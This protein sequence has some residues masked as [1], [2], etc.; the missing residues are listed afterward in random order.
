MYLPRLA[1]IGASYVNPSRDLTPVLQFKES[2]FH[3]A[4]IMIQ[5]T[6][7]S[8]GMWDNRHPSTEVNSGMRAKRHAA[9]H[10]WLQRRL[11]HDSQHNAASHSTILVCQQRLLCVADLSEQDPGVLIAG[12]HLHHQDILDR[13]PSW[14]R[15]TKVH[16]I[17]IYTTAMMATM[18]SCASKLVFTLRTSC[19]GTRLPAVAV[20]KAVCLCT[21][22][23]AYK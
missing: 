4:P 2:R 23:L 19:T 21:H 22:M 3:E 15:G 20:K 10:L 8:S 1:H 16:Y 14:C 5:G 11:L 18:C 6:P 13:Y 17:I 12:Y 7:L 9:A